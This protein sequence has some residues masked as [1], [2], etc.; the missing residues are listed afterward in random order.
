ANTNLPA[1]KLPTTGTQA[2]PPQEQGERPH[3]RLPYGPGAEATVDRTTGVVTCTMTNT[4]TAGFPYTVYPNI[5]FPFAGTPFTVAPAAS[6]TY[7]WDATTTDGR[8][9][10]T[11]HGPDGFVRRFAGTVTRTGQDD[12][13]V[14]SV[15]AIV[16]RNKVA[17]H[18]HNDGGTEVS[19]TL[20]PND[21][22]GQTQTVWVAAN[23]QATVNWPLD[24][25]RYDVTVTAASGTRFAR[26]YAGTVH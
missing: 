4:G 23:K 5:A 7:T 11:V 8:Y 22:A 17:L 13:P 9:D 2:L 19:F 15:E 24:N 26:R 25:G 14:P 18:L 1:V 10:F 16:N 6:K 3:R 21:F 20:T 12:T